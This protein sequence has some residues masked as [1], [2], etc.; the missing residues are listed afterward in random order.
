MLAFDSTMWPSGNPYLHDMTVADGTATG[1]TPSAGPYVNTWTATITLTGDD[2]SIHAT[3][4]TG[5]LVSLGYQ[6]TATGTVASDGTLSGTWTD[7]PFGDHGNWMS[8][9][10]EAV[11]SYNNQVASYNLCTTSPKGLGQPIF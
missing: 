10:G 2:V 7:T 1:G 5:P 3:Y 9:S 8:T 6:Y 11:A 4:V